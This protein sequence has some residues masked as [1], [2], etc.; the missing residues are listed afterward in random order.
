MNQTSFKEVFKSWGLDIND[1]C[2]IAFFTSRLFTA[3]FT[4]VLGMRGVVISMAA[5]CLLYLAALIYNIKHKKYHFLTA[6]VVFFAILAMTFATAYFNPATRFWLGDYEWGFLVRVLDVRKALFA[7]WVVLLVFDKKKLLRDFNISAWIFSFYTVLQVILYLVYGNWNAYFNWSSSVGFEP[8][9]NMN[10]GYELIFSA[11]VILLDGFKKSNR[12]EFAYGIFLTSFAFLVGSR[13]LFIIT[14]CFIIFL[15]FFKSH[16]KAKKKKAFVYLLVMFISCFALLK[17]ESFGVGYINETLDRYA[18]SQDADSLEKPIHDSRNA[19]MLANGGLVASNGRFQIWN[20]S[21]KAIAHNMSEGHIFGGGVYGDRPY[22]GH[23][24]EWGYSHNIFLEMI[25]S[26]GIIGIGILIY[27]AYMAFKIM[28]DKNEPEYSDLI[29]ISLTLSTKLLISDSFWF[30]S[31]F[32]VFVTV[33]YLYATRNKEYKVGVVLRN[34]VIS[35]IACAVC[36]GLFFY[37]DYEKQD[38]KTVTFDQ[39]TCCVVVSNALNPLQYEKAELLS[40]EGVPYTACLRFVDFKLNES[41]AHETFD[42]YNSQK[43]VDIE[44]GALDDIMYWGLSYSDMISNVNVANDFFSSAGLENPVVLCPP[45]GKTGKQSAYN[46]DGL[47][48]FILISNNSSDAVIKTLNKSTALN[49]PSVVISDNMSKEKFEY[50]KDL[51]NQAYESNAFITV[52]FETKVGSDSK[53]KANLQYVQEIIDLLEEKG[54]TFS[55]FRDIAAQTVMSPEDI[56]MKNYL[57]NSAVAQY[58]K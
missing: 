48:K 34:I 31:Y 49:L 19:E 58:I 25:A 45:Y 43:Q 28:L 30:L 24:F 57:N 1:V 36:F 40:Q 8:L 39:P 44:D 22:V 13:G 3:L 21:G 32:W 20:I 51:I 46:L 14:A 52:V 9:Y 12:G 16:G 23:E 55:N 17:V 5:L 37:D 18:I 27:L 10:L 11:V 53:D 35:V 50:A 2:F 47:R 29:F 54:F 7:V 38:F 33:I 42:A 4:L 26:F 41:Q 15:F 6:F 56:T